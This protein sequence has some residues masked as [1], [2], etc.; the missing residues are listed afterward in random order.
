MNMSP[1]PSAQVFPVAGR[2]CRRALADGE[3]LVGLLHFP[4]DF[5]VVEGAAY[6]MMW[7]GGQLSI[8]RAPVDPGL[9]AQYESYG[10]GDLLQQ[11]IW[12]KTATPD[13]MVVRFVQQFPDSNGWA[14]YG[15]SSHRPPAGALSHSWFDIDLDA[16]IKSIPAPFEANGMAIS[17]LLTSVPAW[18]DIDGVPHALS[19]TQ[20]P[21]RDHYHR[22][23]QLL[24][25]AARDPEVEAGL[26][27]K[28]HADPHFC[29]L[30]IGRVDRAFCAYLA[31]LDD[32]GM[33]VKDGPRSEQDFKLREEKSSEIVRGVV[34][35]KN[36]EEV[37]AA[38]AAVAARQAPRLR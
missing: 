11:Q 26:Q 30:S 23:H 22:Y 5:A 19:Q 8:A 6:V 33:L 4:D 7:Q 28:I 38:E 16:G 1:P 29:H 31:A 3:A 13:A 37:A 21:W 25:S 32:E 12:R 35:R 15:A 2:I 17:Q 24:V 14:V 10:I 20:S 36:E 9:P 18:P 34:A 27:A